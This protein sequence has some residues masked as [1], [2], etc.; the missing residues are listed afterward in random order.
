MFQGFEWYCPPDHKHWLRLE[1]ILPTLAALGIT[2]MWIPPACKASWYDENGYDI[3]DLYDLGEFDQ[4]GSKPTKWGSKDELVALAQSANRAGI[5]ILFDAVLNH[6]AAADHSE[7]VVATAVD[8]A[9]ES[10]RLDLL[11]S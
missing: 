10:R 8:P 9:S 6:K 7:K 11:S 2:S 3:Y 4:K 1:R 5:K